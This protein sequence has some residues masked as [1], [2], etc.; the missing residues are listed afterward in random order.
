[1]ITK[2]LLPCN[3]DKC[4][5][6]T[7]ASVTDAVIYEDSHSNKMRAGFLAGGEGAVFQTI[8]SQKKKEYSSVL[9]VLCQA[10]RS[11]SPDADRVLLP[12]LFLW[13]FNIFFR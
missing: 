8:L 5:V 1:M 6:P 11:I 13:I 7:V 4:V 3:H 12:C 9:H 10:C 2:I